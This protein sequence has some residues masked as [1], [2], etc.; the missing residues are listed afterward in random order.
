MRFNKVITVLTSSLA[1][2]A[3]PAALPAFAQVNLDAYVNGNV[4]RPDE[5]D[6]ITGG[7]LLQGDGLGEATLQIE[8]STF[9]NPDI[10]LLDIAVDYQVTDELR[11]TAGASGTDERITPTVGIGYLVTDTED[12]SVYTSYQ[13]GL[14]AD[15]P[16]A[17]KANI[18]AHQLYA[19]FWAND[20]SGWGK[21]TLSS[22]GNEIYEGWLNVA[23]REEWLG[24]T[25]YARSTANESDNYWAPSAFN[26]TGV[27]LRTRLTEDCAAGVQLGVSIDAGIIQPA[28]PVGAQCNFE[29]G[30]VNLGYAY[31]AAF[32]VDAQFE[33]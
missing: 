12:L 18:T 28:Y 10:Q 25:T 11:L 1:L 30:N 8:A 13:F 27:E 9:T 19:G 24:F 5:R 23:T 15:D 14:L 26:V 3:W 2:I 16:R 6:R 4:L 21:V 31:G 32:S 7:V 33:F 29:W 20:V 22:D 17:I